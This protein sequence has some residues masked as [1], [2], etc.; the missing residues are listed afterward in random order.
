MTSFRPRPPCQAQRVQKNLSISQQKTNCRVLH[1]EL[2]Q[3]SDL[4]WKGIPSLAMFGLNVKPTSWSRVLGVPGF[5]TTG[6]QDLPTHCS[7]MIGYSIYGYEIHRM[8]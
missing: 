6:K 7:H 1:V 3:V 5:E 2:P 4:A 8:T